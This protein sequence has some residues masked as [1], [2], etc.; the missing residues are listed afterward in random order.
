MYWNKGVITSIKFISD[1]PSITVCYISKGISYV[2]KEVQKVITENDMK[3][4]N[5]NS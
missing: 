2:S 4:N 1:L 3:K 5:H